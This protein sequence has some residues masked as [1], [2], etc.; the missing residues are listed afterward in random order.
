MKSL[1]ETLCK[2][3]RDIDVNIEE[4]TVDE[5]ELLLKKMI[6]CETK[7][8][9]DYVCAQLDPEDV[10]RIHM[11]TNGSIWGKKGHASTDDYRYMFNGMSVGDDIYKQNHSLSRFKE[12]LPSTLEGEHIKSLE[13]DNNVVRL[14][15][16]TN[17]YNMRDEI[18]D[19]VDK[20]RHHCNL[21]QNA[22]E[23]YLNTIEGPN[24]TVIQDDVSKLWKSQVSFPFFKSNDIILGLKEEPKVV[25]EIKQP[26]AMPLTV[27]IKSEIMTPAW[28]NQDELQLKNNPLLKQYCTLVNLP[29]TFSSQKA[30]KQLVLV[31]TNA[32]SD[33]VSNELMEPLLHRD[34]YKC[35]L[36]D[37]KSKLNLNNHENEFKQVVASVGSQLKNQ[38]E[39]IELLKNNPE[40]QHFY[41]NLSHDDKESLVKDHCKYLGS[42]LNTYAQETSKVPLGRAWNNVLK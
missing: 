1:K 14:F 42:F 4:L 6:A 37:I 40:S 8:I 31:A 27:P 11:E 23:T 22:I 25:V 41:G 30:A 3:A 34:Q 19:V 20:N 32:H 38:N 15:H 13:N 24:R 17:L 26:I 2:F 18:H 28:T 9:A 36:W 7:D 12:A 16:A 5:S 33:R 35:H 21:V 29:L 10:A 39:L